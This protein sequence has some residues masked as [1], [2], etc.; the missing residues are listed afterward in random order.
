MT[1]S[2][3]S[4]PSEL[5]NRLDYRFKDKNLL[6]EALTHPSK[7]SK[8]NYERLE[9]LGDAVLELIISD[10]LFLSFP[11]FPEGRLTKL[12]AN[13][14]CAKSLVQIAL[15]LN[16]GNYLFLGKGE[17]LT[18]GRSKPSILENAVEALIGAVYLDGGFDAAK[19]TVERLFKKNIEQKSS[20][21]A[22]DYKTRLQEIIYKTLKLPIDYKIIE[23]EGPPHKT[24]FTVKLGVGDKIICSASGRSKK[25]AEQNA[26]KQA[27]DTFDNW[28]K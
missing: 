28:S 14:V 23:K 24:V 21:P 1:E 8:A 11:N 3:N 15:T 9:F 2:V 20:E 7:S 5:E 17:E 4:K 16:L 27:L 18:G 6:T 25:E 26:A 10:L 12:R 13:T 19:Q 22:S